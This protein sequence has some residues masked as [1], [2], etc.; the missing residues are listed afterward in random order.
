M[1]KCSSITYK[2]HSTNHEHDTTHLWAKVDGEVGDLLFRDVVVDGGP[3][4]GILAEGR[5]RGKG[6]QMEKGG[7]SERG[8]RWAGGVDRQEEIIGAH[9]VEVKGTGR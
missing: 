3:H 8:W 2:E 6:R 4:L 9:R 7:E 1:H 5:V